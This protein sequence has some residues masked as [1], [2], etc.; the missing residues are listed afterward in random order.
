MD[1]VQPISASQ[2]NRITVAVRVRP[3]NSR[4][5]KDRRVPVVRVSKHSVDPL[6]Q[7]SRLAKRGACLKSE[8]CAHW[9]Y[10]FDCA[11]GPDVQQEVVYEQTVKPLTGDLLSGI[12]STVFAYG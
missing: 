3:L 10:G 4:E 12:N 5:L 2:R 8:M 9:E 11:F 6:V 7:I 1:N